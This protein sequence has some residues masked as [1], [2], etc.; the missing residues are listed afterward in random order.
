MESLKVLVLW[1]SAGAEVAA[2]LVVGLATI[3]ALVR[4]L[5][6]FVRSSMR[7]GDARADEEKQEIRLRLGRWLTLAL[8]FLVA[9]DILRTTVAPTWTEIGQ[10]AAIIALR[11]LLNYFLEKEIEATA[12]RARRRAGGPFR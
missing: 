2:A 10:L 8:E 11:T 7:A 1:C 12:A 5:I 3:E 4:S 9:A 6:A